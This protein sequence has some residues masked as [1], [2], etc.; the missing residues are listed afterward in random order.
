MSTSGAVTFN[1]NRDQIIKAAARKIGVIA[2]GETPDAQTVQDFSDQLNTLVKSLDATGLHLWTE[3]EA[4]LFLQPNQNS[5]S[6]GGSVDNITESYTATTV[7]TAVVNGSMTVTVASVSGIS[8]A[9]IIGVVGDAGTIIWTTVNGAPSGQVVTLTAAM[10]DSAAVGNPVYVYQTR[11]VRPLRV[12]SARRYNFPSAIDTQMIA[13][14]RI[15]YRNMPNK[16]NTGVVTQWFYDPKGG[17]NS[18]GTLSVWP[19]PPDATNGVKFTWMRPIQDF[20]SSANNP[21]LPQEWLDPLVWNLA[22]RMAPEYD[23]PAARYAMIKEQAEM[24]LQNVAGFDR[25]PESYLFGF[26][27]DQTR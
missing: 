2:S 6:C 7:A 14:S 20:L 22:L 1:F 19:S 4:T 9:F 26:S 23:C 15:D 21:D 11:I 5:Y 16:T 25:E 18:T 8:S 13:L 3:A 17:A 27:A 10:S 12:L 24:T